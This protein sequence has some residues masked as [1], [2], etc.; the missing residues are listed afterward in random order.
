MSDRALTAFRVWRWA[1]TACVVALA[2]TGLVW[3]AIDLQINQNSF[4]KS[5]GDARHLREMKIP[6][7]RGM[8][9]DRNGEPLAVSTPVASIWVNPKTF[10]GSRPR[11]PELE[12]VLGLGQGTIEQLIKER[13]ARE[14][15]YLLR[16]IDPSTADAVSAM[17]M[18]GVHLQREYRRY[19]PMGAAAGHVVG[20]TN[21]DDAGQEGLELAF[22]DMLSG[23]SGEKRVIKDRL[24]R[25]VENVER[26][27]PA[28]PGRDLVLSIDRR[29]QSLAY[30]ALLQGVKHHRARAGSVV[31]L[32][33]RTGEVLAIANQPSFN[34]NNLSDRLS[35]RFRNRAVTDLL[36][37]GSTIKP[38]TIAAALEAGIV[39][40]DST[41]DTH[42]GFMKVDGHTVRD[43]RNYGVIDI[44]SVIKKS[45]NVGVSKLALELHPRDLWHM[46]HRAGFGVSTESRFP[47][48]AHGTLTDFVGWTDTH[49]VTLS[50]GYGLAVTP[51][52][53]A[54]AYAALGNSGVLPDVN[55]LRTDAVSFA[56][57]VMDA[58]VAA[59]V[60]EMLEGVLEPGGT[61]RRARVDG[62]R[63]GGKTG[64]TQKSEVGGYSKD[65]YHSIFA[66]LAPMSDPRLAVVVVIDEPGGEAHY[67]GVV[68]APVFSNIVK[69]SLRVLGIAPD[70]PEMARRTAI[71]I[72]AASQIRAPEPEGAP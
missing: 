8:L 26:I 48:E 42:P 62:Y 54:R 55:F 21:V 29:I 23:Q 68:A 65:R 5:E 63:I 25:V 41:L 67:G 45:S 66:G 59:Q 2:A 50:F 3:R 61:G 14:F 22:N 56:S 19:Y 33:V 7:H 39:R 28:Y 35:Q 57:P 51:L 20:F 27:R 6:A 34:P 4:L 11:W 1:F 69:G 31:V 24:G 47:G 60:R 9:L 44:R 30:R 15:V 64:T 13:S 32:D 58:L 52:Q 37:P 36:E 17:K 38:F 43:P 10:V 49:R 16:H 53:L 18:A 12:A 46:F 70:D 71:N 72:A 40:P